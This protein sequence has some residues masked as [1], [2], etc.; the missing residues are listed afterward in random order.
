L[1]NKITNR[2]I[3]RYASQAL[4]GAP[5]SSV[6]GSHCYQD[7]QSEAGQDLRTYLMKFEFELGDNPKVSYRTMRLVPSCSRRTDRSGE[8]HF[9]S[10]FIIP[11]SKKRSLAQLLV[12]SP[13]R[14]CHFAD[15][16][17]L[18]PLD[19]LRNLRRIF[20]CWFVCEKRRHRSIVSANPFSVNPVPECP[21]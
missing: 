12:F 9:L 8:H 2:N 19:F 15:Q 10:V 6:A 20:D 16:L 17:W 5:N 11:P 7:E 18:D 21:K 1:V 3:V 4:A 13:L 14:E